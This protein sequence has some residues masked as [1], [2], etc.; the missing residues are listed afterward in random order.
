MDKNQVISKWFRDFWTILR[1]DLRSSMR[2]KQYVASSIVPPLVLFTVFS[3]LYLVAMPETY[4][5]VVVDLDDTGYS[6][7][8]KEYIG[9]VSSE[10]GTWFDVQQVETYEQAREMIENY[11]VMGIIVIPQ[12]F[13]SNITSG[14]TGTVQLEVQN[15]NWDY[16]KNY[17]QRLDEAMLDF[18]QDHHISSGSLENFEVRIQ[19]SYLIGT[20]GTDVSMLRG[21]VVGI[22]GFYG[23]L[24][25][26]LMGA[27]N[28][29][30]EYDDGT[31]MEIINSPV[32]KSAYLA[33]KQLIGVIFGLIVT[34]LIGTILFLSTGVR[35]QGGLGGIFIL[36]LTFS[37]STW[38]HANIGTI[39]GWK[40]KKVMPTIIMSIIISM[41]LWFICGGFGPAAMLGNLV[42]KLS[43]LLPGTYWNEI[44]YSVTY[45]PSK[46]YIIERIGY[47]SIFT[48]FFTALSWTLISKRGFKI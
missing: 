17:M 24:F 9:N 34:A 20:D 44:L 40:F 11:D 4:P 31:I 35:F 33:S 42:Y 6:N 3:L 16:P 14:L 22:V 23:M 43:R 38:T 15:V 21:L 7:E 39:I 27:L 13:G 25:G 48:V 2:V 46:I 18:N 32:S 45:F 29:A 19:K 1:K 26:L 8:M 37:L 12:G 28:I 5:V 30:K 41:L 47:L 10:F 36:I